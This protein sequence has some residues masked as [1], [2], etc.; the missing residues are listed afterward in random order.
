MLGLL[1]A[2]LP[3]RAK[4]HAVKRVA[5]FVTGSSLPSVGK[6]VGLLARAAAEV[7]PCWLPSCA[8]AH[9][10]RLRANH[11]DEGPLIHA[12][13]CLTACRPGPS[14]SPTAQWHTEAHS[15]GRAAC[16]HDD[17]PYSRV[18]AFLQIW[19]DRLTS[20]FM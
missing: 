5:K 15:L 12:C 14:C 10:A 20:I 2:R 17:D 6:E 11:K 3:P 16:L 9:V 8:R 7:R 18:T 19:L 13:D 1:F 4:L